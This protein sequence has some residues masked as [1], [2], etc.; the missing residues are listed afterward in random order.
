MRRADYP[1]IGDIASQVLRDVH[2]EEQIK[3]AEQRVL[4]DATAPINQSEV[5]RD[6]VKLAAQCRQVN[7]NDPD[8]TYGD[9]A[10]FMEHCK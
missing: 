10:A 8:V 5:A 1:S 9:L 4:R 7:V 3:T 2:A 6:L